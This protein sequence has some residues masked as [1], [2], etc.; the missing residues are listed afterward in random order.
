MRPAA[1][2]I[3]RFTN[4]A[5]ELNFD[6]GMRVFGA[7]VMPETFVAGR[8]FHTT[9]KPGERKGEF[10][11]VI[12][13]DVAVRGEFVRKTSDRA[14]RPVSRYSVQCGDSPIRPDSGSRGPYRA[15]TGPLLLDARSVEN[16]AQC[17]FVPEMPL[18]AVRERTLQTDVRRAAED[19]VDGEFIEHVSDGGPPVADTHEGIPNLVGKEVNSGVQE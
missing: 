4:G 17:I 7:G 18:A 5:G 3:G 11:L 1:T 13:P 2:L 15:L 12:P 9:D 8:R 14:T 19:D 16:A 10:R 6:F